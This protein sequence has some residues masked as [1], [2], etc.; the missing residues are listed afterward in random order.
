MKI[1][2]LARTFAISGLLVVGTLS[3]NASQRR[4]FLMEFLELPPRER[5]AEW[6]KGARSGARS[7]VGPWRQKTDGLIAFGTDAVSE[8]SEIVRRDKTFYQIQALEVLCDMDRYVPASETPIPTAEGTVRSEAL[9]IDGHVNRFVK[10][11]GRRIGREGYETVQWAMQQTSNRDLS[12]F[13]RHCSGASREEIDKLPLPQKLEE[14]KREAKLTDGGH[15]FRRRLNYY[16]FFQISMSLVEKDGLAAIEPLTDIVNHERNAWVREAAVAKLRN[17]DLYAIRLRGT[18]AGTKAIEAVRLAFERGRLK[19]YATRDARARG[20]KE[21][22]D[23]VLNDKWLRD[24]NSP[25]FITALAFE[26]FYQERV[27]VRSSFGDIPQ[28]HACSDLVK[29]VTH[30]TEVDPT[31]PGWDYSYSGFYAVTQVLHP[32][33]QK[34]MARYYEQWKQ[35]KEGKSPVCVE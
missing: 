8:L 1:G 32:A 15:N 14:W 19:T 24:R 13:A 25:L 34:K 10:V 35:F 21:F 18:S 11:D 20:W 28:E 4:S 33:F 6:K 27:V 3:L 26:H 2:T 9:N 31:F 12:G 7:Y 30:L 5:V 23:Q 17:I 29:F 16:R 22:S